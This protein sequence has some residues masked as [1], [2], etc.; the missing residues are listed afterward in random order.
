MVFVIISKRLEKRRQLRVTKY[1][2]CEQIVER[3]FIQ[4]VF[5]LQP[6]AA[7]KNTLL[8]PDSTTQFRESDP[9]TNPARAR[10]PIY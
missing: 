5:K 9:A 7:N 8:F 3:T 2:L 1:A 6:I 10:M 4:I